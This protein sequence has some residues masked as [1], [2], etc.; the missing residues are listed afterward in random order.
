MFN[1]NFANFSLVL[2]IYLFNIY[3]VSTCYTRDLNFFSSSKIL[4]SHLVKLHKNLSQNKGH[5][6]STEI[7]PDFKSGK[8]N[9]PHL[10]L[11]LTYTICTPFLVLFGRPL[12]LVLGKVLR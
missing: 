3:L 1:Y 12:S 6:M 2:C 4:I 8:H 5:V 7:F 9:L 10:A 11:R